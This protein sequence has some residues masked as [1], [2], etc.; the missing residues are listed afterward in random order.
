MHNKRKTKIIGTVGPA[1]RS[2]EM[3]KKLAQ[4]G[5]DVA[6]LNFSH[7]KYEDFEAIIRSLREIESELKKPLGIMAD[8]Q[9]PK[10]R[11]GKI[12]GLELELPTD[13]FVWIATDNRIAK[14]ENGKVSFS[15]GYKEFVNDVS[16]GQSV[17]LDDGLIALK[18]VEKS[19]GMLKCKVVN[20]G[21]LKEN[22]GV[23][24]PEASF[25]STSITEKDYADI[26]FCLDQGVDFIALS[27]VRTA[28]E[29]RHLK[30]FILSRN[31]R[32]QVIAKIEKPDALTNLD[33]IIDASDGILVA[34]GDLAVEVGNERVPVLQKKI[35]R[36]CNLRG[37]VVII[38]TQML[39][40]MVDNPRPTRA[41]ASDVANGIVDGTDAL[42]LSN[43]TAVGKY[44][45]EAVQMMAKIILEMEAEEIV[46]P[47]LHNQWQLNEQGQLAIAL[48][49]SAVRLSAVVDAKSLVVITQSGRAAVL[50][51][52]CRPSTPM[53][54]ITGSIEVYRQLALSWGVEPLYIEDMEVLIS[55]AGMF[56]A[57]G[58]RLLAWK[59]SQSGDRI[60][61]TAGL[62]KLAH[63]ST[64]TIKVHHI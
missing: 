48:L 14:N 45:V 11:V 27:F 42:M 60:V 55:Q 13:S 62:P 19:Q 25:S 36:H 47:I 41:E 20:G 28:Q 2:K 8:I 10:M 4:E 5:M 31:K 64:N 44:P 53:I 35:V 57:V 9:G 6:R 18:V 63:G 15:V 30:N 22:K 12:E 38:A 39:M 56:E 59:L 61:I 34:R 16:V 3:L 43:E 52:K 51:S 7:G 40:S 17:L 54:A 26:L 24:V 49:Q 29:V 50:V 46:Q 33:E 1:V 32:T 21:I 37:K 58:Q 23:N